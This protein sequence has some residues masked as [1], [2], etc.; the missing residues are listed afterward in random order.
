M[1]N[2]ERRSEYGRARC[3][4][5]AALP[6][7]EANKVMPALSFTALIDLVV[8]WSLQHGGKEVLWNVMSLMHRRV[9]EIDHLEPAPRHTPV[10]ELR[11]AVL[12]LLQKPVRSDTAT[13][14]TTS[15]DLPVSQTGP[16]P[17]ERLIND[18][19]YPAIAEMI[20]PE[21]WAAEHNREIWG[22]GL[23]ADMHGDQADGF[24]E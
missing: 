17:S 22:T 16:Y 21:S 6:E 24:F 3:R 8:D 9:A 23:M 10:G 13:P 1:N 7:I 19:A 14:V 5:E 12:L 11:R 15:A 2:A 20:W 4:P 18:A